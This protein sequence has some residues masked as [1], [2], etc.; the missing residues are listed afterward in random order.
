MF[1]FLKVAT[2]DVKTTLPYILW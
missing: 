2:K 1:Q